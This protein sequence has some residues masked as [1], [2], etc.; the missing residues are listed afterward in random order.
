MRSTATLRHKHLQIDQDKLDRAKSVLRAKTETETIERALT[1]VLEEQT[2]D[3]S[4]KRAKGR[5]QLNKVFR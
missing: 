2:L 3:K 4:L 5:L 1:L